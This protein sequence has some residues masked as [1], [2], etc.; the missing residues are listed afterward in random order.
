MRE[1]SLLELALY[2]A[3]IFAL[4]CLGFACIKLGDL[5]NS[6]QQ[7]MTRMT[8]QI[9]RMVIITT[10][11]ATNIE[12]ATR[13]I[14]EKETAEYTQIQDM[15]K[16]LNTIADN[17]NDSVLALN[18]TLGSL[19]ALVKNSDAR[20]GILTTDADASIKDLHPV[21]LGLNDSLA[22]L[23]VELDA[24]PKTTQNINDA[25]AGIPP[26]EKQATI[27]L[28]NG[29]AIS[30]DAAELSAH[31]KKVILAPVTKVKA[32]WNIFSRAMENIIGAAV[33]VKI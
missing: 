20:M 18:G 27:I 33:G 17:A 10:G 9:D 28:T 21:M 6:A 7:D 14:N 24:L 23:K 4:V 5:A 32:A 19:N 22:S 3:A 15:S 8:Q 11:T 16:K 30:T 1:K 2:S 26:I 12:K 13:S 31:Y 25:L 29:A